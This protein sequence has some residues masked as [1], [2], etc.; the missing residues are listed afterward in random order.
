MPSPL[1]DRRF[2]APFAA[3]DNS[4]GSEHDQ[5]VTA[6]LRHFAAHGLRAA[7]A[8]AAN[9]AAACDTGDREA[10]AHWLSIAGLLSRRS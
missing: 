8:A 9:A 5:L 6:A 3:N 7:E 10:E 4:T 2:A 1:I